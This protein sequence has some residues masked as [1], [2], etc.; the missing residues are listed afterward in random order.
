MGPAAL[1]AIGFGLVHL[2][3]GAAGPH[4]SELVHRR[5]G[6]SGG[7]TAL[8]VQ[9]LALQLS[10]ALTGSVASLLPPG[11]LPWLL[12]GAALL[13]AALL[14]S[15]PWSGRGGR[16]TPLPPSDGDRQAPPRVDVCYAGE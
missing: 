4:E 15:G 16:R 2:G 8:S 9:S 14:W 5:V 7:A 6:A 3:R 11:P 10:A 13:A 12:G 1:A